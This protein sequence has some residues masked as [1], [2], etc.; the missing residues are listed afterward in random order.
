MTFGL[1][2]STL[3]W[4]S[5]GSQRVGEDLGTPRV[6]VDQLAVPT[7]RTDVP[8]EP[9]P[10]G[11]RATSSAAGQGGAEAEADGSSPEPSAQ[12]PVVIAE[13]APHV[14]DP[15]AL[16]GVT[17]ASGVPATATVS[18]R[19]RGKQGWSDW[20]VLDQENRTPEEGRPGTEPQWVEWADA[21][22][23][24]VTSP[25]R[26]VPTDLRI[27]TV[28]PGDVRGV[29][30]SAVG[31]PGII[32][33]SAWH[34]RAQ[35]NCSSPRYGSST[36]GAVIH[37]TVGSNSYS[38]ADSPG[39]V[40]SIQAY[41]ME[42]NNWCDIGYNF[43]VDR[44]GQIFEGRGGGID[45]PVRG[46]HSGNA[47]VN[48]HSVGVSLMGTFTSADATPAMKNSVA[49][50]VA[51]R[52]SIAGI[53]AKGVVV[54]AGGKQYNRISGHQDVV[55]TACPGK[56]VYTWIGAPGGLRDQVAGILASAPPA[57]QPAA[58]AA[59]PP[60]PA[61]V[62]QTQ[63][64]APPAP[65]VVTTPTGL[66]VA[67][68][69]VRKLKLVWDAVPGAK[70]YEVRVSRERSM[71]YPKVQ[72]SSDTDEKVTL[73]ASGQRYYVQVRAVRPDGSKTKWSDKVKTSTKRR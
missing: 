18:V 68:R 72:D 13:L 56:L 40:R 58:P 65:V 44:F 53:P 10:G 42:A 28:D 62:V 57:P 6:V 26:A 33:R 52:F 15:F 3:G 34:A 55:S 8:I 67:K 51:W 30:P 12:A 60:A 16:V 11:S 31:Q 24:R 36:E 20:T 59:Q 4:H 45:R 17:W 32:L 61:P 39:I 63:A 27:A 19:W 21:V 22:A 70:K 23:V 9:A 73:R 2:G 38:Q 35:T 54:D 5:L 49:Q 48:E 14:V 1:L 64:P 41:H 69:Y 25:V 66:K 46:A 37:H 47:T 50:L 7:V 43:L 71:S 29:A